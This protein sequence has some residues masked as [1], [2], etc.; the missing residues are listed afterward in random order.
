MINRRVSTPGKLSILAVPDPNL[1]RERAGALT[2]T[3]AILRTL[4]SVT[5]LPASTTESQLVE[6]L[7]SHSYQLVLLPW[8]RYLEWT[9][10][11]GHFGLSRNAGPTC[12][13]YFAAPVDANELGPIN[14][15]QRLILLDFV[16]T[17]LSERWRLVRSLLNEEMRSGVQPLVQPNSP[18]YTQGWMGNEAPG[19]TI[20]A[21]LSLNILQHSPW[22]ERTRP[23]QLMTLGLWNLAFE[24]GRALNRSGW[25]G[26]L[27]ANRVRAHFEITADNELLLLRLCY[28][29]SPNSPRSVLN[30]FWPDA[31]RP[32]DF[33]QLFVQ[34][35]DFVRIHPL[36]E[37]DEIEVVVG[38]TKSSPARHRPMELRTTWIEPLSPRIVTELPA[39]G[40]EQADQ[41]ESR[42]RSLLLPAGDVSRETQAKIRWLEKELRE[43]DLRIAELTRGV[44]GAS[45]KA[46]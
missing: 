19:A 44:A 25:L 11:E 22:R 20:D 30:D 32:E 4:G 14:D 33:R 35:A 13:G 3:W 16:H 10:V 2:R 26:V 27:H 12:A 1:G 24:Q 41:P 23:I 38:L 39:D 15:Y 43:R 18:I 36:M 28:K 17:Q 42:Y 21:V 46:A 29:Q 37:R 8:H 40:L 45:D 31:S 9:L 5:L 6:H 34:T 7:Q